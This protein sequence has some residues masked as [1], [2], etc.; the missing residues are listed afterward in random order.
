MAM[1][2]RKF[3]FTVF[4]NK[5]G[6]LSGT[7]ISMTLLR[8]S[9]VCKNTLPRIFG[10]GFFFLTFLKAINSIS[11]QSYGKPCWPTL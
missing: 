3:T 2:N 5:Y 1:K 6:T 11:K 8:H 7:V 9:L 10:L 4:T